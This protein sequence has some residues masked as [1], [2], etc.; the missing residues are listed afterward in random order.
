MCKG[1]GKR[2]WLS[3]ALI[4]AAAADPPEDYQLI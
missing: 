3:G 2:V 4:A 1:S